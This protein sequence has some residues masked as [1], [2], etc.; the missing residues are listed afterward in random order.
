MDSNVV[1]VGSF[2]MRIGIQTAF[3]VEVKGAILAIEM[4]YSNNFPS[5][6]VGN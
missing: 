2:T 1:F 6:M 4:A 5:F 3:F